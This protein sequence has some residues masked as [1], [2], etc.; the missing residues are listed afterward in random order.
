MAQL[1]AMHPDEEVHVFRTDA[2]GKEHVTRVAP[3]L[4]TLAA[5]QATTVVTTTWSSS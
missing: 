2:S 5:P 3:R 4:P 1:Q